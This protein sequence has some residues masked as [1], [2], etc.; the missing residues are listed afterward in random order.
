[1]SQQ[2]RTLRLAAAIEQLA[3]SRTTESLVSVLR[4]LTRDLIEADGVAIILRDGESCRYVAEDA[5]SPLWQGREFSLHECL[6]GWVMMRGQTA[7]VPDVFVDSRIPKEAYAETF[8]R[9][10][11]M[12]PIGK[13]EAIAALGAYWRNTDAPKPDKV[14]IL[15]ALG[16]AASTAFENL[17]LIHSL[18]ESR[19]H[20]KLLANESSHRLKNT[21]TVVSA[22]INLTLSGRERDVETAR[23]QLVGR[24]SALA[25]AHQ[26]LLNEVQSADLS[27]L[28]SSTLYPLAPQAD[29]ITLHGPSV[30]LRSQTT[31][32]LTLGLHELAT[33][34]LKYG[35]LSVPGGT[36]EVRWTVEPSEKGK[37][38]K[39]IWRERGGPFVAKPRRRGFGTRM[40]EGSLAHELGAA[41][42]LIFD[43]AGVVAHLSAE[44]I[45][46]ATAADTL[47]AQVA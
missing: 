35:A 18:Q 26:R 23:L 19:E 46:G 2:D 16:R 7:I 17:R 8:V 34:A 47:T 32:S 38:L 43:P 13:P 31:T 24:I 41:V 15:E 3:A 12:V 37:V 10:A 25:A 29:Q 21:F 33:N 22:L 9:S 11:V 36:V 39:L 30:T 44:L 40:I 6:S 42:S 1:M 27:D 5:I 20:E 4:S 14:A 45:E 28:I